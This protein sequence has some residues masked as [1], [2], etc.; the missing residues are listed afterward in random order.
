MQAKSF[1]VPI[2]KATALAITCSLCGILL[3]AVVVKFAAL[4]STVVKTV[5]QFIKVIAVFIGCFFSVNGKLGIVK[6]AVSGAL[7][8]L[9][10]YAIFSLLSGSALF[11]MQMLTDLAFTGAIGAIAG[12]L[13]V[14][15]KSKE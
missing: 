3:F 10:L 15:F 8:T 4:S 7:C 9:L 12:V 14:N 6:G 11:G 13:A 1:F 5:N 2:L